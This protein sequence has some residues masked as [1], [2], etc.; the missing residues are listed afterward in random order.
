M[1][2]EL[3]N[4]LKERCEHVTSNY[5][6][7]VSK[8][9]ERRSPNV[10]KM[11]LPKPTLYSEYVPYIIVQFVKF[12]DTQKSGQRSDSRATMRMIFC[13]YNPDEEEG[14]M[15][16]LNL[17]ETVRQNLERYPV[18]GKKFTVDKEAGFEGIVYPQ[19]T[20]QTGPYFAGEMGLDFEMPAIET[21]VPCL[22]G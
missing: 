6:L 1:L 20:T 19:D 21:E 10:Y 2:E 8:Q 18:V 9:Q 13:V 4:E 22:Y 12:K 17:M 16:L 7:L 3:V 5:K 11:R 15:E 14:A